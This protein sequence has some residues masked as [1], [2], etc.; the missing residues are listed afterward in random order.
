MSDT[1]DAG[2]KTISVTPPKK[3]LTLKRN[4][5][6][7][8]VRQIFEAPREAYTRNLLAAS[9]DPDPAVQAVRRAAREKERLGA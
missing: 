8:T 1:K 5:E 3:T 7:G 2:E 4:V 9:P 6:Q